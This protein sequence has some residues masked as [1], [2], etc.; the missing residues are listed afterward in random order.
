MKTFL[1]VVGLSLVLSTTAMNVSAENTSTQEVKEI[2]LN[3]GAAVLLDMDITMADE[4]IVELVKSNT[5]E[6]IAV[7]TLTKQPESTLVMAN[8]KEYVNIRETA[9]Q[10]AKKL[11]VLYKDCGG[12]IVERSGD[13]TKI[14]SGDVTGW[15]K[16]E[17]LYFG[18]DAQEL[19]KEVGSLTAYSNTDTL[20]VRKDDSLDAGVLGL[21]A[22]GEAVE[23]IAQKDDWVEVSY[24]GT[25]GYVSSEYV[26]VSFDIDKAESMEAIRARQA[27]EEKAKRNARK[28]AVLTN[29]SEADILAALI[30]CEAG[31]EPYEGQLAV[32]AVVMNRI[33][34]G[35]YPNSITE[36]IYASG[37]F[38]PPVRES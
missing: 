14:E 20:R 24:E 23:A 30:Q 34:S 16:N 1:S 28:E 2:P 22:K 5:S 31:G 7:K 33:R 26:K 10:D 29:A 19:A 4:E 9:D 13:W 25:T 37:Q 12:N 36:V 27:Q 38:T 21:L 17:Y 11:G 32:G 6:A 18:K 8:V 3:A 35:A 15:V